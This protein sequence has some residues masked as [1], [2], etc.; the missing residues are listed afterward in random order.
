[1]LPVAGYGFRIMRGAARGE[2]PTLP[3]W[4]NWGDLFVDGLRVALVGIVYLLPVLLLFFCVEAVWLGF[5]FGMPFMMDRSPRAS[6]GPF[7]TMMFG[8]YGLSFVM[9]G[10]MFLLAIPLGFLAIA[11]VSRLAAT[12][13]VGKAFEVGEVWRLV[14]RGFSNYALAYLAYLGV[15]IAASLVAQISVY[16]IIL[17]CL[18]PFLHAIAV[19]YMQTQM[20]ALFGSAY[21]YTE[22]RDAP[23]GGPGPAVLKDTEPTLKT[24]PL[25]RKPQVSTAY[26]AS[27]PET[28]P[29]VLPAVAGPPA[30]AEALAMAEPP[31]EAEPPTS[32]IAKDEPPAVTEPP[33]PKKRRPSTPRR[34][35]S[36]GGEEGP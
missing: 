26:E 36:T 4:D 23:A 13:S 15:A 10:L 2:P 27:S 8:A 6:V 7:L 18:Y 19:F 14:K 20:G 9:F 29:E 34:K 35:K 3:E 11:A 24:D 16:T 25:L 21:Y 12:N 22:H 17:C 31:G 5:G 32:Q 28:P 33:A 30:T 1:M